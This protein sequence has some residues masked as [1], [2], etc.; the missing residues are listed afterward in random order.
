MTYNQKLDKQVDPTFDHDLQTQVSALT[1]LLT[2]TTT[3][4]SPPQ[5]TATEVD[6]E[7][8]EH[9]GQEF[10]EEEE[11]EASQNLPKF[12]YRKV[13]EQQF[14]WL[15]KASGKVQC[16]LKWLICSYLSVK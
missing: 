6:V 8:P 14:L 9:K 2:M 7:E 15:E 4:K 10:E 1:R 13:W 3:H 11:E 12:R 5:A 16:V